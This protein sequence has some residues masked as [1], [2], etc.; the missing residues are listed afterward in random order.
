MTFQPMKQSETVS[1]YRKTGANTFN[2]RGTRI[3]VKNSLLLTSTGSSTL[4]FFIGGGLAIGTICLIEEDQYNTY[5]N[6]LLKYFLAEGIVNQHSV[7]LAGGDESPQ[8]ILQ[9]LPAVKSF[10][11]K[12]EPKREE[13]A[14]SENLKIAWRYQKN[15]AD[16]NA[17]A[18]SYNVGYDL[19]KTMPDEMISKCNLNLW[20]PSEN[21][22]DQQQA[23][24]FDFI[25]A[26]YSNLFKKAKETV[27]SGGF[28]T[29]SKT[30]E[31]ILR[32]GISSIG[33]PFWNSCDKSKN[34]L[35][36]IRFLYM[37]KSL[38]RSSY[39]VAFVTVPSYL[40]EASALK[41]QLWQ[42]CDYVIGLESFVGSDVKSNSFFK[43]YDGLLN[44]IK[45]PVLNGFMPLTRTPDLAFKLKKKG[46]SIERLHLPPD[47]E[48]APPGTQSSF[49][50]SGQ[51]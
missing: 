37:L 38:L 4:D 40:L 50:C 8:K 43:D 20:D 32:I 39:A 11:C 25:E 17:A 26:P 22:A 34:G 9:E 28:K 47:V 30:C 15:P 1:S 16:T 29:T 13:S 5:S 21:T 36:L 31:S 7:L 24:G 45:L 46:F 18:E 2:I 51:P 49:G 27:I 48:D 12:S 33:S 6:L 42:T 19:S 14:M 23:S 44:I 3:S 35:N 41:S 10:E